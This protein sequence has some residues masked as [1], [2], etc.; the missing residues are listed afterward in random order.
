MHDRD[1]LPLVQV[2]LDLKNPRRFYSALMDYG[3]MLAKMVAN[4][5]RR[6]SSYACQS[7]FEGSD[8][9]IRGKILS[10]LLSQVSLSTEDLI[11]MTGGDSAR[12]RRILVALEDEGFLVRKG[13]TVRLAE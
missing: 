4:P 5:N 13:K 7:T 1:L 11:G 6:S 8:R 2:A 10:V 12:V 3:T 9:Q